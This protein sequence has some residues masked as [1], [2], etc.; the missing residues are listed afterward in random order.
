MVGAE[1][2]GS[3]FEVGLKQL[4]KIYHG[5]LSSNE[6]AILLMGLELDVRKLKRKK[7]DSSSAK[8]WEQYDLLLGYIAAVTS[9]IVEA[10]P[11]SELLNPVTQPL[12]VP[13]SINTTTNTAD[14]KLKEDSPALEIK[15]K[16]PTSQIPD[17]ETNFT[18]DSP[19]GYDHLVTSIAQ[20]L[21]ITQNLFY[22]WKL[23]QIDAETTFSTLQTLLDQLTNK[24]TRCEGEPKLF[25]AQ[26]NLEDMHQKISSII[27]LMPQIMSIE[28]E[29]EKPDCKLRSLKNQV[30]KA[31]FP[32]WIDKHL[33][34]K[35]G[36]R[37]AELDCESLQTA[38]S[39]TSINGE[40]LSDKKRS[41]IKW[42]F[43]GKNLGPNTLTS[44]TMALSPQK[45][46]TIPLEPPNKNIF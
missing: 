32:D 12:A 26:K 29:L 35:I 14:I 4:L 16:Q 15:E 37:E 46:A 1:S 43:W 17:P 33:K 39:T 40:Q 24:I 20:L 25:K 19:V 31:Q 8:A 30:E 2:S 36:I 27:P 10:P 41:T 21:E 13:I 18:F 28:S 44:S 6:K 38:P 3:D 9:R 45:L 34:E 22:R 23:G 7:K 11:T 42:K 5:D